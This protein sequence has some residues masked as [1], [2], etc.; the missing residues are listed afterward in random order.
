L[1]KELPIVTEN[2]TG[3]FYGKMNRKKRK[4]F[5]NHSDKCQRI[6]IVDRDIEVKSVDKNPNIWKI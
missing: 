1:R 3:S 6:W 5:N 4:I 2:G